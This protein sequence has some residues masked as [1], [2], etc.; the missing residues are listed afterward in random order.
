MKAPREGHAF[1]L[2]VPA[3]CPAS[4]RP[5]ATRGKPARGPD[6]TMRHLTRSCAPHAGIRQQTTTQ[7]QPQKQRNFRKRFIADATLRAARERR[8]PG[9]GVGQVGPVAA[10]RIAFALRLP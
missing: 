10:G 9:K 5:T 7:L 2:G 4:C 8:C 1:L 6:E 3:R